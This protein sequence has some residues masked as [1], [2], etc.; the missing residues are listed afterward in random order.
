MSSGEVPP[1]DVIYCPFFT[2]PLRISPCAYDAWIDFLEHCLYGP[3][4]EDIKLWA[5]K[6]RQHSYVHS[7]GGLPDGQIRH[8]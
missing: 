3:E 2:A 7:Q 5:S 4:E 6:R 1:D 8:L